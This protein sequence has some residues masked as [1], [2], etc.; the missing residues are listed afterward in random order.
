M[1]AAASMAANNTYTLPAATGTAGQALTIAAAPAPTATTATLQWATITAQPSVETFT[2]N[3]NPYAIA[4]AA[5]TTYLRID[6]DGL[7]A[8][9]QVTI[10]NGTTVGQVLTISCIAGAPNGINLQDAGNLELSGNFN[11]NAND[12]I[13]L[14]WDGV[15]W[16]E[17]A[18]RNN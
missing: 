2:A 9:R 10:A 17:T 4:Q 14:I 11:L 1:K 18:R 13:T 5:T 15:D 16:F 3:A 6:S 8:N 7:A 12:T